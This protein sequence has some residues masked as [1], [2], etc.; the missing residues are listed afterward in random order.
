MLWALA[1]SIVTLTVNVI[2]NG[3]VTETPLDSTYVSGTNV[4]LA[5]S[6]NLWTF[7]NWRGGVSGQQNPT[8]I[9]M[10]GNKTVTATF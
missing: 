2:G 10:D 8:S 7:W 5:I 6:G 1:S 3:S 9:I 4:T